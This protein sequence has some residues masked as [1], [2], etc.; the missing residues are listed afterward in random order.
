MRVVIVSYAFPPV[1]GAGVQRMLKLAKYLPSAGV[2]PTIL[3]VDNASVP[4]RD[5]TL[6]SDIPAAVE[7]IRARTLEPGYA[8]KQRA[9]SAAADGRRSARSAVI[10]IAKRL[11]VPDP[12]VLW[13]PAASRALARRLRAAHDDVVLVSGPPFSQFALAPI[14]RHFGAAVVL[15]YR[16]EWTTLSG[17]I[18]EMAGASRS[19]SAALESLLLRSQDAIT[20]ATAAFRDGLLARFSFLSPERVVAIEN[21]YDPADFPQELPTPPDDR[22]VVTYVGTVFRLTRAAGLLA[23]V[24]QVHARHPE[25]AARLEVRFVGRIVDTEAPFFDGVPGVVRTG[26]VDHSEAVMEQARCHLALCLLADVPGAERIYPAKIFE[27]MALRKP[28][29]AL[30]PTGA[31]AKLVK[32]HR[33][34]DVIHPDDVSAIARFLVER[35]VAHENGT[36]QT[37]SAPIDVERFDRRRQARAFAEVMDLARENCRN[38]ARPRTGRVSSAWTTSRRWAHHYRSPGHSSPRP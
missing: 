19:A 6:S 33:V 3:S 7:V 16:D 14:A 35:L 34:G 18:Y 4:L 30:C 28:C 12:Q 26:Y 2:T 31:L 20:T 29:L 36:L 25:L 15:D 24:R 11:L 8:A 9:W 13:L 17:G 38:R 21:G 5:E 23:A 37:E 22:L 27:T 10:G 32:A 1:G